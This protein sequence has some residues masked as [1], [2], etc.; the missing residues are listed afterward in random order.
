MVR[1]QL[2]KSR[3]ALARARRVLHQVTRRI[4]TTW[5]K[6]Q[7]P[8]LLDLAA[9]VTRMIDT[10]TSGYRTPAFAAW[11]AGVDR[12]AQREIQ[13]MRN[14][15]LKELVSRTQADLQTLTNLR[16]ADYQG[17]PV[18]DGDTGYLFTWVFV[19]GPFHGK[20]VVGILKRY[21]D[22]GEQLI[23]EAERLRRL[24]FDRSAAS[25]AQ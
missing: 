22:H 8:Y 13:E 24:V 21:L 2:P 12:S 1:M 4:D 7:V 25:V 19:G 20:S 14:S 3:A 10:K 9:G 15:E 11:W 18:K 23:G 5:L 17:L 16:A 6:D